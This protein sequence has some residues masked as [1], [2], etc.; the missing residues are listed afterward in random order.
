MLQI[1]LDDVLH[2][3]SITELLGALALM[4]GNMHMRYSAS[5]EAITSAERQHKGCRPRSW[6]TL[7]NRCFVTF[8]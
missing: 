6:Q 8:G 1:M 2:V 7:E 5:E 4:Q 3:V